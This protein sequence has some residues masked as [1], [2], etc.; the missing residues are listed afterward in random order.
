MCSLQTFQYLSCRCF[1]TSIMIMPPHPP[2]TAWHTLH[3]KYSNFATKND[4]KFPSF[5]STQSCRLSKCSYE[6]TF[7]LMMFTY[8]PLLQKRDLHKHRVQFCSSLVFSHGLQQYSVKTVLNTREICGWYRVHTS[9]CT[10]NGR[11]GCISL[12]TLTRLQ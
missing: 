1:A 11:D 12:E 5:N 3:H 7:Q 6:M 10:E 8:Y 2:S 4:R 9:S